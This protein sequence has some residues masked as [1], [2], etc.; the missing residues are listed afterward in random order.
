MSARALPNWL[1]PPDVKPLKSSPPRE[2]KRRRTLTPAT[3][4][5]TV[6]T[7]SLPPPTNPQ[8]QEALAH[9]KQES[10]LKTTT[11]TSITSIT[12]TTIVQ[13]SSS[14]DSAD[15]EAVVRRLIGNGLE[16]LDADVPALQQAAR[17]KSQI[18]RPASASPARQTPPKVRISQSRSK[19]RSLAAKYN[20]PTPSF[21][22]SED[23]SK[24]AVESSSLSPAGKVFRKAHVVANVNIIPID[25]QDQHH[26]DDEDDDEDDEPIASQHDQSSCD[27]AA[28]DLSSVSSPPSPLPP[29]PPLP[30][31]PSSLEPIAV[32]SLRSS[33]KPVSIPAAEHVTD[34]ASNFKGFYR[35]EPS[36]AQ[37]P[38][39]PNDMMDEYVSP[40]PLSPIDEQ[41]PA[42]PSLVPPL[43]R[44]LTNPDAVESE[45]AFTRFD[46]AFLRPDYLP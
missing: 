33:D 2:S 31:P 22:D 16:P 7:E 19:K 20:D 28:P 3:P 5:V 39:S 6:K 1:S 46:P 4:R 12:S 25:D 45:E 10:R 24:R 11:T 41:P 21:L 17:R 43:P 23:D 32:P 26:D 29:T 13:P 40:P 44:S 34:D 8:L 30:P 42:S 14:V 27:D 36:L 37:D 18:H 9:L 38:L 35:F 15:P